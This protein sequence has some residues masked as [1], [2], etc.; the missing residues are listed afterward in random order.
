MVYEY[1]KSFDFRRNASD[2]T[3]I[4]LVVINIATSY[5]IAKTASTTMLKI[6]KRAFLS[7]MAILASVLGST[8]YVRWFPNSG[9][10][11]KFWDLDCFWSGHGAY[12][13]LSH[14]R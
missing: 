13:L 1:S 2:A 9:F 5:R 6:A 3:R 12:F 11:H 8:A 10:L 14:P 7:Q 4:L